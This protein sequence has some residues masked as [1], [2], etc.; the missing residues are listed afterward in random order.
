MEESSGIAGTEME[1]RYVG[2]RPIRVV[3]TED[4]GRSLVVKVLSNPNTPKV[5]VTGRTYGCMRSLCHPVASV[6]A[7]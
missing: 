2:F 1:M 3:V 6:V 4:H 7:S 5:F